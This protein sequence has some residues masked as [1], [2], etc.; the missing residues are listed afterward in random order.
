MKKELSELLRKDFCELIRPVFIKSKCQICGKEEKLEL[1]H[2]IRF[3]D[4]LNSTLKELNLQYYEELELYTI[5]EINSIRDLMLIKQQ[6]IK[7]LTLCKKC[8][9]AITLEQEIINKIVNDIGENNIKHDE[10]YVY[11]KLNSNNEYKLISKY[12]YNKEINYIEYEI[13]DK[14]LENLMNNNITLQT[15]NNCYDNYFKT[16]LN[17]Y[18][19][20]VYEIP[21]I[22]FM[23]ITK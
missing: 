8:H 13:L 16:I 23:N 6:N 10:E 12:Q 22:K 15:Y 9:S 19:G 2:T 17:K 4:L 3:V 7:Y 21:I 20:R 11:V 14:L 5:E 18:N 1:H